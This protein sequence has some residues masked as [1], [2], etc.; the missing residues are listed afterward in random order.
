M[1]YSA[2]GVR[3]FSFSGETTIH[4]FVAEMFVRIVFAGSTIGVQ[5]LFLRPRPSHA[6]CGCM[7]PRRGWS[8]SKRQ[9][10]VANCGSPS[11]RKYSTSKTGYASDPSLVHCAYA[12]MLGEIPPQKWL[13]TPQVLPLAG[14]HFTFD[15]IRRP[16]SSWGDHLVRQPTN[17][18]VGV[19]IR[20]SSSA[21]C[22]RIARCHDSVR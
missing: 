4:E 21:T 1:V 10:R 5:C 8:S 17:S 14:W 22:E 2:A 12:Q 19:A 18:S 9:A 11:G 15:A 7:V 3:C 16:F 6:L 20:F 13:V